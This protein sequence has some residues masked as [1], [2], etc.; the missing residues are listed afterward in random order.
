MSYRVSCPWLKHEWSMTRSVRLMRQLTSQ[1]VPV[2]QGRALSLPLVGAWEGK[3]FLH[4]YHVKE[5]NARAVSRSHSKQLHFQHVLPPPTAREQSSRTGL[6][7]ADI[8]AFRLWYV[9]RKF[10]V[11]CNWCSLLERVEPNRKLANRTVSKVLGVCN[12]PP[13]N[14]K[15]YCWNKKVLYIVLKSY[16]LITVLL[17]NSLFWSCQD[18]AT[19]TPCSKIT[20]YQF[21][22]DVL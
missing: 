12:S 8:I 4:E 20:H 11:W 1:D 7:S 5:C 13:H 14:F 10:A 22:K 6:G 19:L 3:L 16:V 15:Q 21:L 17:P 9:D 2:K 18:F